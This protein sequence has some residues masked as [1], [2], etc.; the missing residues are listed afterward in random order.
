MNDCMISTVDNPF[1]PFKQFDDW[2]NWDVAKGYNTC[3]TLAR[4]SKV[5]NA[6]SDDMNSEEIDRA[7]DVMIETCPELFI[8]LFKS[9]AD[10]QIKK[11]A[12]T[13]TVD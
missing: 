11:L 8:K 2:F 1:N 3:G 7:M 13:A 6:L 9:T 5:S 10:A 4:I 12:M